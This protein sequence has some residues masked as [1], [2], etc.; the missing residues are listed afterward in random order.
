MSLG[1][2]CVGY[3]CPGGSVGRASRLASAAAANICTTGRG[4]EALG[5]LR[6]RRRESDRR[7]TE[8]MDGRTLSVGPPAYEDKKAREERGSG[9]WKSERVASCA[10]GQCCR[11]GTRE[12]HAGW[13]VRSGCMVGVG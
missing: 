7:W 10:G 11:E 13:P 4:W 9:N 5:R 1:G 2:R 3:G 6:K 12:M 8:Q